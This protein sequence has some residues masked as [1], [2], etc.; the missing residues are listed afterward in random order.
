MFFSISRCDATFFHICSA[1][2]AAFKLV[3]V[4]FTCCFACFLH[5]LRKY[6]FYDEPLMLLLMLMILMLLMIVIVMDN[7]G[8]GADNNDDDGDSID[9][10]QEM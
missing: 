1:G 3:I 10:E 6:A 7:D 2:S 8:D 4:V 9:D 5:Q